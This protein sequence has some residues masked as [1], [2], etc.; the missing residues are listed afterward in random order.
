[1]LFKGSDQITVYANL[2]GGPPL[3]AATF[4]LAL[5]GAWQV[6]RHERGEAWWRFVFYGLAVSAIPAS[7]TAPDFNLSR[8]SPLAVFLT[9]LTV[10]ALE[11]LLS[12]GDGRRGLRR[13]VLAALAVMLL[14][15]GAYSV[16]R[17]R[18]VARTPERREL[19]DAAF[20]EV[21]LPAAL[22][23]PRRPVYIADSLTHTYIQ[24]FWHAAL[25]GVD[26]SE[27]VVLPPE[28][29]PPL[30]AVVITTEGNCPRCPLLARGKP[31]RVYVVDSPPRERAPLPEGGF[32]AEVR[33]LDPPERARAGERLTVRALVRNTGDALWPAR[34]RN[35]G[36][37]QV[38]LGARWLDTGGREIA[39]GGGRGPLL[40]D[41]GPGAQA[42]LELFV[43]AP[44]E[45]GDYVLELDMLQEGVS[46]FGSKGVKTV[47]LG[48]KVE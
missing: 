38:Q 39:G 18:A 14:A 3:L 21:I 40:E 15:Q 36:K 22:A 23:A 11:R 41:L 24:A 48:V 35:A 45:A 19:F 9:V 33:V 28:E 30:G 44:R 10:P 5:A 6:V 7:L 4:L 1:L 2:G 25:R 12:P 27:F 20:P 42:E 13:A 46:W 37:F 32:R 16:W 34:E 17:Y 47:R 31:Y 43:E 26:A 29:S 8:L